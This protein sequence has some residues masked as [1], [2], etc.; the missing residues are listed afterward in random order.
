[1][2]NPYAP[3][4]EYPGGTFGISVNGGVSPVVAVFT[5]NKQVPV[6]GGRIP[7]TLVLGVPLAAKAQVIEAT[8]F[9]VRGSTVIIDT[10]ATLSAMFF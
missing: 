3:G 9:G 6:S 5:Y 7:T 1:M 8:W 4:K 2:P 10:P